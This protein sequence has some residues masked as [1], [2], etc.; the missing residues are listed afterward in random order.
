MTTLDNPTG[1]SGFGFCDNIEKLLDRLPVALGAEDQLRARRITRFLRGNRI[2]GFADFASSLVLMPFSER[3]R[4]GARLRV[5]E[6]YHVLPTLN[7]NGR[8]SPWML[9]DHL[10]FEGGR[11]SD[12]RLHKK[13]CLF[14]TREAAFHSC[15]D[16]LLRLI[17]IFEQ[18]QIAGVDWPRLYYPLIRPLREQTDDALP[19]REWWTNAVRLASRVQHERVGR[20]VEHILRVAVGDEESEDVQEFTERSLQKRVFSRLLRW[21]GRSKNWL[22]SPP[23]RSLVVNLLRALDEALN[24]S[25]I[26]SR[27]LGREWLSIRSGRRS[28]VVIQSAAT[29]SMNGGHVAFYHRHLEAEVPKVMVPLDERVHEKKYHCLVS[30]AKEHSGEAALKR[31]RETTLANLGEDISFAQLRFSR[32]APYIRLQGRS[33]DSDSAVS[34]LSVDRAVDFA[35]SGKLVLE[36]GAV[37][38]AVEIVDEFKDIRHIFNLPNLNPSDGN[39]ESPCNALGVISSAMQ[40]MFDKKFK[41]NRL[42]A[43]LDPKDSAAF[44]CRA[45][46]RILNWSK[47]PGLISLSTARNILERELGSPEKHLLEHFS[48]LR[49]LFRAPRHLFGQLQDEE[50]PLLEYALLSDRSL[51]HLACTSAIAVPLSD[52]GAPRV[53]VE[54]CL[55]RRGYQMRRR[56]SE[57]RNPG[58]FAWEVRGD[59]PRLN[60]RLKLNTY[61][62]T[63]VGIG[64][65]SLAGAA[66]GSEERSFV[67]GESEGGSAGKRY[68]TLYL[69]A[70]GHDFHRGEHTIWDCAEVLKAAGAR[71][72]LVFDEGRNVF[73]CHLKD[74]EDIEKF[75]DAEEK[76][77]DLD[78]WFPVPLSFK[79]EDGVKILRS[80]RIRASL[81]FWQ[82][83]VGG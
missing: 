38:P 34:S 44:W 19:S 30:W 2:R 9:P 21:R 48:E 8:A 62:C 56:L 69:L 41:D 22:S 64:D 51:R 20:L 28:H 59:H 47:E 46:E 54:F 60:I 55:L 74:E 31:V 29:L 35:V 79:Y 25:L 66:P 50:L 18:L 73:Q 17:V 43:D 82:E 3:L 13:G 40:E 76:C 14:V 45:G 16:M 5:P 26:A 65:P 61:P 23:D 80:R 68:N 63:I 49:G 57:V 71:Y 37:V 36:N 77:E 7:R 70:W 4:I 42:F 78:D 12:R 11:I 32:D 39:P 6:D 58:D 15:V 53:W 27:H 81:A 1:D 52:L 33:R 10:G 24:R 83:K 75:C 67:E 72:A